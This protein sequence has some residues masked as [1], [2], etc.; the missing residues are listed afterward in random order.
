MTPP[1]PVVFAGPST[2]GL[3]P[4]RLARAGVAWRPPARRGDVLS[5][6]ESRRRPGVLVLCDGVFHAEPAVSHAELCAALD[7][8]WQVWGVSSLGAIRA[9][10][11]AREGMR[12]F[13]VV[14]AMYAADPRLPDDEACLL[15]YPAAPWFPLSEALVNV[16]EALR[17]RGPALGI[18]DVAATAV[19]GEL[20]QLWFGDRTPARIRESV[21][22]HARADAP[23]ADAFMAWLRAHPVKALDLAR[24]LATR[25]WSRPPAP[26]APAP[27]PR[28]RTSTRRA[29]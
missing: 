15:H 5:L 12:G 9:V 29:G 23:R 2:Y 24:L 1:R 18:D 26:T 25:P 10:E 7:A 4:G 20:R 14:H 3:A 17:R 22:R 6:V 13:G 11:L 8:G 19:V 21:L 28:L 16:R 27:P